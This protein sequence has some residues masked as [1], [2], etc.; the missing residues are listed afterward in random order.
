MRTLPNWAALR[1]GLGRKNRGIVVFFIVLA[2]ALSGGT[3]AHADEA[4]D[5]ANDMLCE[6]APKGSVAALPSA[7]SD[8]ATIVCT[9]TGQALAPSV[10]NGMV[11]WMAQN[12]QPFMLEAFP[13][14]WTRPD[15][16]SKYQLRFTD[17]GVVERTGDALE[18]TLKMWDMG[19][20]PEPRPNIDRVV[21]LD[22]RSAWQ[23][24][25]YNLFFYVADGRPKWL[26]VCMNQCARNAS[27]RIVS[28]GDQRP[29]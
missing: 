23:G 29:R 1:N 19:F 4:G 12:G 3:A 16:M 7:V 9:P 14:E 21:Q 27:I 24:A 22:A 11:L 8:W 17:F 28:P 18:K 2:F 13:R 10:T 5:P 20:G 6:N 26:I 15:S 25:I